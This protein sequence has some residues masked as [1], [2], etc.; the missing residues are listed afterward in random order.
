MEE[1]ESLETCE[2][3]LEAARQALKDAQAALEDDDTSKAKEII[4]RTIGVLG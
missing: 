4:S 3:K 1:Q 2:E